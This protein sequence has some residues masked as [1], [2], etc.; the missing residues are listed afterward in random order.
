MTV[1]EVA[2]VNRLLG[3]Q[4]QTN[5]LQDKLALPTQCLDNAH[6]DTDTV[7]FV[8]TQISIRK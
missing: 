1:A 4:S 5:Q 7:Q 6:T 2:A 8:D 3:N